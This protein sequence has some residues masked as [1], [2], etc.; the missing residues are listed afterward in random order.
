MRREILLSLATFLVMGAVAADPL[1]FGAPHLSMTQL[2]AVT[3]AGCLAMTAVNM[4]VQKRQGPAKST[5]AILRR[6]WM[7]VKTLPIGLLG[8]LA[9][10]AIG[11]IAAMAANFASTN[12][13]GVVWSFTAFLS[14]IGAYMAAVAYGIQRHAE[15]R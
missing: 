14:G 1:L 6:E 4:R 8:A 5:M 13:A 10:V 7:V 9:I 12:Q 15:A 11:A 3:A 2:C